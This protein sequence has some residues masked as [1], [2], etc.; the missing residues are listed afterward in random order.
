MPHLLVL[1][2]QLVDVKSLCLS[3]LKLT[4]KK[5][6]A[7]IPLPACMLLNILGDIKYFASETVVFVS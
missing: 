4:P 5:L 7:Q 2:P 3:I 6:S 1:L